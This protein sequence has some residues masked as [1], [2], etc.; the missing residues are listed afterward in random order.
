[1][2][3]HAVRRILLGVLTIGVVCSVSA[4][5]VWEGIAAVASAEELPPQGLYGA[6]SSFPINSTV[7]V[8]NPATGEVVRVVIASNLNDP[9]VLL[10]LSQAAATRV[11]LSPGS[12]LTVSAQSVR[13]TGLSASNPNWDVPLSPDPDINPGASLGDPNEEILLPDRWNFDSAPSPRPTPQ[14]DVLPAEGVVP[15]ER[16]TTPQPLQ[17]PATPAAPALPPM[18]PRPEAL[19]PVAEAQEVTPAPVPEQALPTPAPPA[20]PTVVSQ[21]QITTNVNPTVQTPP[22]EP[23][24]EPEPE[25]TLE[26]AEPRPPEPVMPPPVPEPEDPFSTVDELDPNAA[27]VQVGAY[28]SEESVTNTLAILGEQLPIT[29]LSR[30][31]R[32]F[33]PAYRVFVGPLGNDEKGSALFHARHRGF[34]DAFVVRPR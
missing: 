11:G 6:S 21:P 22:P 1:M 8:T 31:E 5:D 17:V 19:S 7:D 34:R 12:T 10:L 18:I 4:Q 16:D 2:R 25:I 14:L 9:G 26:P 24:L 32:S 30:A 13:L 29:V 33:G 20:P 15:V 3:R 27:Y 28:S 23:P